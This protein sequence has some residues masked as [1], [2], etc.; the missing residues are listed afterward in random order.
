M[1]LPNPICVALDT[2]DIGRARAFAA[3]LKPHVGY[4]KIGLEFFYAHG[5]A[6]YRAVAEAGL[7]IFL[8]LKLHDIPNTVASALRSLVELDPVPAIINV[9]ATGGRDMMMAAA[10]AVGG[11]CKLIAVT[12]LTSLS[13]DDLWSIGFETT[14]DTQSH[15]RTLAE[16]AMGAGLDGVVCSPHDIVGIRHATRPGFITVVPGIRPAETGAQDQK[17]IATPEAALAAGGD[18]LVI[19]RAI[20]GAPD[21]AFAAR[22]IREALDAG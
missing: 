5:R 1:S 2:P 3:S 12:I 11:R 13:D 14:R 6:G 4:L 22:R 15:A 16:L 8:D 19:G 10:D 21:P 20:T 17:R 18:I 9:H 7:P